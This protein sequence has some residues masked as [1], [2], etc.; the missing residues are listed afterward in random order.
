MLDRITVTKMPGV[1]AL[2]LQWLGFPFDCPAQLPLCDADAQGQQG[3]TEMP[4][5]PLMSHS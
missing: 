2:S 5:L 4:L 1:H 3:S